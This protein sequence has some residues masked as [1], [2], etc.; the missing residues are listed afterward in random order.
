[1][2][3]VLQW[4]AMVVT[5]AAAWYVASSK[6]G[7]R[8]VGFWLYLVGNALW[9]VW[10]VH[11]HAYALIT[12]QFCLAALNIRGERKALKTQAQDRD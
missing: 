11:A 2:L 5:I 12:L 1:M 7:R 3:D 4:P 6:A 8:R 9:I 10:G